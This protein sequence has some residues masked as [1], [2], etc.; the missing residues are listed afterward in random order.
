MIEP[1]FKS[2]L[3]LLRQTYQSLIWMGVAA[4]MLTSSTAPRFAVT[5]GN[6]NA[7][8]V[9]QKTEE[10]LRIDVPLKSPS[11]ASGMNWANEEPIIL[12]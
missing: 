10:S 7:A 8:S 3:R 6:Q 9:G 12:P 5:I 4:F 1:V 11:L 2:T